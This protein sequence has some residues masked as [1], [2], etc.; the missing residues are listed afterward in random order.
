MKIFANDIM[1]RY[2]Q[3]INVCSLGSQAML[4]KTQQGPFRGTREGNRVTQIHLNALFKAYLGQW[5]C[6]ILQIESGDA[7][8]N[9]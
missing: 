9:K 8:R 2:C 3:D 7:K 1:N 4:L 6:L 5:T